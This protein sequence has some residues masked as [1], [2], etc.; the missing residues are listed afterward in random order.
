MY[1]HWPYCAAKC[2][3]CDFNS[4]IRTEFDET[5]WVSCITR[6]LEYVAGLQG[7]LRPA[8]ASVFFGGGTPSLMRGNA[9][10]KI[11]EAIAASAD[12]NRFRDYRTAG[13]NRLSLGVQ[14]LND[15]DLK[16]LGRL[17]T[18]AEAKA[19]LAKAMRVFDRVSLDLIY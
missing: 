15:P 19:A 14:A 7:E 16:A 13:V 4:H 6:E 9:V 11:V 8:V 5:A 18:A 1:V 17:H 12:A 3:Y 2:P 10:T